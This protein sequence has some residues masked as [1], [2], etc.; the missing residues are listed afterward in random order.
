MA[1]AP[2]T[3][4]SLAVRAFDRALDRAWARLSYT[5]LTARAHEV[6]YAEPEVVGVVD[7]PEVRAPDEE[8]TAVPVLPDP[9]ETFLSPLGGMPGGT[10]FG[11]V[12]HELFERV[13]WERATEGPARN[14][15][16]YR[17]LLDGKPLESFLT[18]V[19]VD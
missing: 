10:A 17:I 5:G 18:V 14:F 9:A 1:A 3:V 6:A 4:P 8:E 12:V 11:T 2:A 16:D 15:E 7:E 13:T 19:S